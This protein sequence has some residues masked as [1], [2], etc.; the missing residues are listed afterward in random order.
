MEK[1]IDARVI[2]S[3]LMMAHALAALLERKDYGSI[4]IIDIT[5]DA[6]LS[7]NTFYNNFKTKDELFRYLF[8][9]YADV[10]NKEISATQKSAPADNVSLFFKAVGHLVFENKTHIARIFC[11]DINHEFYWMSLKLVRE[12]LSDDLASFVKTP[13]SRQQVD[14]CCNL[15]AGAF[16]AATSSVAEGVFTG[17]EQDWY[18]TI[19]TIWKKVV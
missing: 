16:V 1:K 5:K 3:K 7:K 19:T 18:S 4:T 15:F 12:L 9:H 2:R 11:H 10:I 8:S 13:F 17:D 14:L 6:C